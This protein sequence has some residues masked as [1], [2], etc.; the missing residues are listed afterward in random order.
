M[1]VKPHLRPHSL[2]SQLNSFF[3]PQQ[4]LSVQRFCLLLTFLDELTKIF[5]NFRFDLIILKIVFFVIFDKDHLMI[6]RNVVKNSA[7]V[8]Y[9]YF[10]VLFFLNFSSLVNIVPWRYILENQMASCCRHLLKQGTVF[11]NALEI[12]QRKQAGK[13][14]SHHKID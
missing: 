6:F 8:L 11:M 13:M 4:E 14:I 1:H 5:M 3:S 10:F 7:S 2:Y 12:G 9:P